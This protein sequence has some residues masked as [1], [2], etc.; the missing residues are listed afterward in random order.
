MVIQTCQNNE[1]T[2]KTKAVVLWKK[3]M[4]D[5][6]IEWNLTP[7]IYCKKEYFTSINKNN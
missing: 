5:K 2:N 4:D 1:N 3:W 7:I 6:L